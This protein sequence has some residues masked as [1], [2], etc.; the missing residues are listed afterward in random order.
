MRRGVTYCM[1]RVLCLS[2]EWL[3]EKIRNGKKGGKSTVY[4]RWRSAV[5]EWWGHLRVVKRHSDCLCIVAVHLVLLLLLWW[6]W[7]WW[8]RRR[9]DCL[10]V[11]GWLLLLLLRL[12]TVH[13]MSRM[14]LRMYG[15]VH[16]HLQDN[17][18]SKLSRLVSQS[19]FFP[20]FVV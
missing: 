9:V 17:T 16:H 14:I 8:R 3:A 6:W 12:S 20:V 15:S 2:E 1:E 19:P 18:N 11:W 5:R 7:W 10:I 4:I 13:W